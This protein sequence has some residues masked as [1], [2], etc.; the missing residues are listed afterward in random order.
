VVNI[1]EPIIG[2]PVQHWRVVLIWTSS[3][4]GE[5][6]LAWLVP[7]DVKSGSRFF[8]AAFINDLVIA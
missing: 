2:G 1:H 3:R 4:Y 5:R 6:R 7:S 8:T